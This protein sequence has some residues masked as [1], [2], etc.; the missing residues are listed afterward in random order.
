MTFSDLTIQTESKAVS[1]LTANTE[2]MK[3]TS[4]LV[5]ESLDLSGLIVKAFYDDNSEAVLS[6]N[7]YIVTG[8]DSS[9]IGPTTVTIHYNGASVQFTLEIVPLSITSLSVKYYPA[10][11]TYYLGDTFDS[12]GLVLV[13]DYNNGFLKIGRASCRERVF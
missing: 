13:A 9:R 10:K 12:E 7:D 11:T 4:Y 3:K 2:D 8:F 1:S 5:G 6:P